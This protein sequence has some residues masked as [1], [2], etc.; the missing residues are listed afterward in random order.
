MLAKRAEDYRSEYNTIRPHE[1]LSWNRPHDVHLGLA[2]PTISTFQT[3]G[4]AA[5]IGDNCHPF[6]QQTRTPQ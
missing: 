6:V 2:S 5:R 1:A 4:S 3:T